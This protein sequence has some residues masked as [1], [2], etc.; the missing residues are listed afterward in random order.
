MN[1]PDLEDPDN[2][3][4]DVFSTVLGSPATY[5]CNLGFNLVGDKIRTCIETGDWSGEEPVCKRKSDILHPYIS[6]D[7]IE[8]FSIIAVT[9][10]DLLSP[11]NG[12]VRL[13]GKT[14]G[15]TASYSCNNG[16]VLIGNQMRSCLA[17]G[18]WSGSEPTCS[19]K[20]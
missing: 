5:S 20:F 15:S 18:T 19:S 1:C 17:T 6:A 14:F 11:V 13:S 2:G 7:F 12:V 4:V 8:S 10:P 16:L 3:A 9:C